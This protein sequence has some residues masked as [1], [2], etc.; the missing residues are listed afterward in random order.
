MRSREY[1][2]ERTRDKLLIAEKR[3]KAVNLNDREIE[4]IQE[5]KEIA[6]RIDNDSE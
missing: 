3:S 5:I 2:F 4:L 1:M 6:D